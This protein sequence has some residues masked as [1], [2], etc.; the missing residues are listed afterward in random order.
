MNVIT[1]NCPICNNPA[2][3]IPETVM[4]ELKRISCP[5]CGQFF[6]FLDSSEK[7]DN[8]KKPEGTGRLN[9]IAENIKCLKEGI[10]PIWVDKKPGIESGKLFEKS[11]FR[12]LDY[13]SNIPIIHAFKKNNLLKL[14]AQKCSL[15]GAF[16]SVKVSEQDLYSLKIDG[17]EEAAR[18]LSQLS[19]EGLIDLGKNGN[20]P[21]WVKDYLKGNSGKIKISPK[22]WETIEVLFRGIQSKIAFLA[23]SFDEE[24]RGPIKEA[25]K[26]AVMEAGW[27]VETVDDDPT[28]EGIMDKIISKINQSHFLIADLTQNK[29]GVY[30]EAGYAKGL[31]LPVIYTIKRDDLKNAHFDVKH[32]NIITW[33]SPEDLEEKLK[34]RIKSTIKREK[35]L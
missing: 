12:E 26:K 16:E 18:W 29:N 15:V 9:I 11:E 5:L 8:F 24:I 21:D 34:Y 14:F 33:D 35:H 31:T 28:N 20:N 19:I 22:G 30:F 25:V 6:I 3:K 7:L 23:Q 4:Q 27:E 10:Y 17:V 2:S 32:L 13:Y 1:I